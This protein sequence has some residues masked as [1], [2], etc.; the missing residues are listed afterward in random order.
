VSGSNTTNQLGT[1]G[2]K[3]VAASG[4]VP[5]A[6]N[7]PGSWKDANGS[8]WLFGGYGYAASGASGYL[9]DLWKWAGGSWTWV[10]GSNATNQAGAY[11]SKGVADPANVPGS[12][13]PSVSWTDA[14]G[15][16]W[17][18]GGSGY[19][20]SGGSN[21][22][23]D[24]WT[25]DGADWT[26]VN[27]SNATNQSGTYG[28]K[29]I[30]V[31]ENVPG[32]R[33]ASVSWTDASGSLWLFGGDGY[34]ASGAFGRLNDLWVYGPACSSP[35]AP[36]AGNG[37]AVCEGGTIALTAS[38]VPGAT[39]SWTGPN[40]YSS[41]QQNP[42]ITNATAAKAG[43]YRVT[44]TLGGCVS[45]E[46]STDVVVLDGPAT[47]AITA[48]ASLWPEQPFRASV[49]AIE[50]VTYSWSVTNGTVT[51]GVGTSEISVTAG[52]TGPVGISVVETLTQTGCPSGEAV[53]SIPVALAVTRNVPVPPCRLFDTRNSGT[54]ADAAS[55]AL[56]AGETRTFAI[57]TRCGIDVATA[58]SLSV[59]VTVANATAAGEL[60]VYR[61]DLS[62][63]PVTSAISFR[64]GATRANN[65]LLELSRA[66]DG[67]FK[68][69]NRSTGTVHFILDVNGVMK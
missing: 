31:P 32:A 9:N 62:E 23:N 11:G 20:A 27:G 33:S 34:A 22:L 15:D 58:R 14:E 54:A 37:G 63:E 38:T 39:Y 69:T 28:T 48:P 1:Y 21:Y 24:L 51:A 60:A 18:F 50:G 41:S 36:T 10:S 5:G 43:T 46:G 66:G 26:W 56:E 2:I 7:Y 35:P 67:T 44:A 61:G 17:L 8:L 29:G 13:Q 57:G 55:P 59:N 30:Q 42:T 3:G 49:P 4:N 6:R 47:P 16:F 12:R 53:V 52:G 65:G 25:W 40:G 45:P 19:A 68:V 64:A